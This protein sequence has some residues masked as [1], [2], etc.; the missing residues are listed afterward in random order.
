MPASNLELILEEWIASLKDRDR[1]A[2]AVEGNFED[3]FIT[4]KKANATFEE[5]HSLLPKAIKAHQPGSG[6]IRNHYR[7]IKHKLGE[8][9]EKE[10][11]D[12]WNKNVADAGTNALYGI[13]PRPKEKDEDDD[14]EPKVF[15]SMSA[16]EYRLQ[17]RHADQYPI[18]DTEELGRRIQTG[19]YNPMEDMAPILGA[20]KDTNDSNS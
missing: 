18:L 6:L 16:K 4:L 2:P 13:F 17:R 12:N 8:L 7:N 5:A 14:P 10:F 1:K 19:A 11:T 9:T 15:G 3:L 20:K